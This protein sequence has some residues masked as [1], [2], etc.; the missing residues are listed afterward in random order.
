MHII[1]KRSDLKFVESES[2]FDCS[3]CNLG[4][5]IT[6]KP[7]TSTFVASKPL[8]LVHIVVCGPFR[9]TCLICKRFFVTMFDSFRNDVDVN[10]SN[11]NGQAD[12]A[13]MSF[14]TYQEKQFKISGEGYMYGPLGPA[15]RRRYTSQPLVTW[16]CL[17]K[18]TAVS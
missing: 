10:V 7:K 14:I 8:E 15:T 18:L 12:D 1:Q 2:V 17:I 5:S 4:K 13:V 6:E 16:F 3:D 9:Y 11:S